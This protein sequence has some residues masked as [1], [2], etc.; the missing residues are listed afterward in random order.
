MKPL[1]SIRTATYNHEKYIAQCL[2]GILMQKTTFPFEIVIG[3]DCS[4]DKTLEIVRSYERRYP[5]IIRVLT[6]ETNCGAAHNSLKIHRACR[7]K[8]MAFC[9][10]DD[11]WIDPL[12]LQKQVDLMEAHPE[13][14]LCFHDTIIL[15]EDKAQAPRYRFP[16]NQKNKLTIHDIIHYNAALPTNSVL[17]RSQALETLPEWRVNVFAGDFLVQLWSAHQGELWYIDEPMSVYR[18]HRGGMTMTIGR[19][20]DYR[21]QNTIYLFNEFD[22]AT[23]YQYTRDIQT[24]LN[25]RIR[26]LKRRKKWGLWCYCFYPGKVIGKVAELTRVFKTKTKN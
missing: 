2:E 20:Y 25:T 3:D 16:K 4:T 22:K 1:V 8:Y 15:W 26:F 17:V 10:G 24:A 18:K 6:S 5:H 23:G 19:D 7:G 11:Y 9:E 14:S 12:K 13:C 21:I